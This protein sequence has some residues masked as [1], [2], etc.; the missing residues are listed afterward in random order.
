MQ[1]IELKLR[2][3]RLFPIDKTKRTFTVVGDNND[4][5]IHFDIDNP[6]RAMF[7]VFSQD[8]KCKCQPP[9]QESILIDESGTIN[10]PMWILK[11]GGFN[12][13]IVSDG[14][15]STAF[16]IYVDGSIIDQPGIETESP[17]PSQ[18]E[19]L[20]KLVNDL[21]MKGIDEEEMKR[22]IGEYI[23]EHPI[24]TESLTVEQ[25]K[26]LIDNAISHIAKFDGSYEITPKTT[27]QILS[28]KAK[29]MIDDVEIKKIP[30]YEVSNQSGT[31]FYIGE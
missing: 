11:K 2:D 14:F 30:T 13:G 18:V 3:K 19:Q 5:Y 28:T 17:P 10:V 1:T 8:D 26:A 15:A 27:A 20:I 7:A 23:S 16:Y 31:T 25:V 24:E 29:L 4:Y 9:K 12:V 22:L 21:Q 6:R